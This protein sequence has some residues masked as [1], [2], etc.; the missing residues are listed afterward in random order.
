MTCNA[1]SEALIGVPIAELPT[2]LQ[3]ST[4][5]L[6][7]IVSGV[8]VA[9]LRLDPNLGMVWST[10]TTFDF[11]ELAFTTVGGNNYIQAINGEFLH[12]SGSLI[13]LP[14]ESTRTQWTFLDDGTYGCLRSINLKGDST[15]GFIPAP[16]SLNTLIQLT[17][18]PV[19]LAI[20]IITPAKALLQ[21]SCKGANLSGIVCREYC[22]E[23]N[24]TNQLID[25]CSSTGKGS[26]TC[27][28]YTVSH[29]TSR[30]TPSDKR[31]RAAMIE[32]CTEQLVA[33]GQQ[34]SDF[35][36]TAEGLKCA[37]FADDG[38]YA[39]Y[40]KSIGLSPRKGRKNFPSCLES[41]AGYTL[42]KNINITYT[43]TE[44]NGYAHQQNST[45]TPVQFQV[46]QPEIKANDTK[47]PTKSWVW[48]LVAGLIIVIAAL[49]IA[50]RS[51]WTHHQP[52]DFG[53]LKTSQII[54]APP[55]VQFN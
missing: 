13:T 55:I 19:Q 33:S 25:Y 14:E 26:E 12:N 2:V 18:T 48:Y 5:R 53:R 46:G 6:L 47:N 8:P 34:I 31:L 15:A 9:W 32:T 39:N 28:G 4:A 29:G 35:L 24:C 10:D 41:D 3:D 11:L 20:E 37:C 27:D 40:A 54:Q 45:E 30:D 38:F 36:S 43:Q 52:G 22:E 21:L 51:H 16:I 50:V 7:A 49:I 42:T 44:G 23:Y 17:N 1:Y